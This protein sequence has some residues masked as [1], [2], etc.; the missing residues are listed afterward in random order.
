M[1]ERDEL[2]RQ[3]L[4]NQVKIKSL[5]A[6]GRVFTK[7]LLKLAEDLARDGYSEEEIIEAIQATLPTLEAGMAQVQADIDRIMGEVLAGA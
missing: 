6:Y 5:R 4:T 1:S 2:H 7:S 3:I